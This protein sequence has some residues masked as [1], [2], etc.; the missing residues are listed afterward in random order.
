M[1]EVTGVAQEAVTGSD[2]RLSH[3]VV[4]WMLMIPLF[5][6]ASQGNLFFNSESPVMG[7]YGSAVASAGSRG[8][9]HAIILSVFTIA[10]ILIGS[11]IK[12]VLNVC[13]RGKEFV[14]LAGL[15]LGSS[16]WSQLPRISL[17]ASL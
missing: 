3:L 8:E 13:S 7:S 9:D 15:A 16:L 11:R 17:L 5:Y 14:V 2:Q 6:F 12:S 4:G 10:L 1:N